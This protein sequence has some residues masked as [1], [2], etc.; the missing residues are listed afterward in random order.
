[1]ALATAL[2]A[3]SSPGGD[4]E[5]GDGRT[6]DRR[7]CGCELGQWVFFFFF[8]NANIGVVRG[9]GYFSIISSDYWWA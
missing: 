5:T 4:L 7:T 8:K 9:I 3:G 6:V 1:M 2:A